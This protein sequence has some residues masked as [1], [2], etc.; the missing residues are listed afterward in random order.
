MGRWE[1]EFSLI[2]GKRTQVQSTSLRGMNCVS[3]GPSKIVC[4]GILGYSPVACSDPRLDHR[5][6]LLASWKTVADVAPTSAQSDD[7]L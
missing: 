1:R 5:M 4:R 6:L 3:E 7:G 2:G